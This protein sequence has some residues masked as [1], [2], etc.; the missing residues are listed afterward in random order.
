LAVSHYFHN[1][2]ATKINEIRLYEDVLV[3]SIKIMGHDVFYLPRED[4]DENDPIFGENIHSRFERAYQM[5]MYLANVEGW[6]GDGDFF[7][8]FGLE[9][10]DNTNIILAKRTFDKYMPTTVT[11]RP[12][13]GDLLFVPVMNK[14]FEIKYVEEE[15]LFFTRG[16]P[17]PYIYELRCEAFRYANE[18]IAT[19][20]ERIDEIEKQSSYNIELVVNGEGDYHI[21]EIVYQGA[22]LAYAVSE[23]KVSDWNGIDNKLYLYATNGTFEASKGNVIGVSSN[24]SM[25]ISTVDTMGD[26]VYYDLFN[27]K[28]IQSEA[29]NYIDLSERNPFGE[30]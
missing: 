4:F 6:E 15:L 9:I 18:T 23:A 5:E 1:Y 11:K 21:D 30:P 17:Y 25:S 3:E 20:V 28:D 16:Y 12:R 2:A 14:I 24:T 22:N 29:N 13:E 26:H 8:K 10:R 19:G 7:S 27:N